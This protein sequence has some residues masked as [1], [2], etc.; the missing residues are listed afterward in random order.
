MIEVKPILN[1]RLKEKGI[2]QYELH[3][4]TKI[5]QAS[6]SRFDLQKSHSDKHLFLIARALGI[7]VEDLFE[8]TESEE[9]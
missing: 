7:S 8:V 6:L 9:G 3:M 1:K 2:T 4:K 5:N